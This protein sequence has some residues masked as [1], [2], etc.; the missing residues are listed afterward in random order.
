MTA[1]MNRSFLVFFSA[2]AICAAGPTVSVAQTAQT[3]DNIVFPGK[4]TTLSVHHYVFFG[5]NR[6][7]I[8]ALSHVFKIPNVE[9]AQITYSWRQLESVKD[10]YD[11]S[12]IQEDLAFLS[13][14]GKRLFIQIQDATF[15]PARIN[16][17]RYLLSDPVYSGGAAQQINDRVEE[18]KA[19]PAGWVARRWDPAVQER[20]HKLLFALGR[21]FDG[22]IEGINF[23]ETSLGFGGSGK[24]Y[25]KGYTPEIYRDAVIT[26]MRALKLA[27]PK[28]VA[29]Q[30]GNFMPGEW[31]PTDDKGYLVAVYRAARLMGVGMGG[32]DLLPHRPGQLG[33]SYPLLKAMAGQIPTGI[34]V[35]DGNFKDVN[36]KTGKPVTVVELVQFATEYLQVDYIF[37]GIEE[38]YFSGQV[39]PFLGSVVK[40]G[41]S[42]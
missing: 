23:D 15:D 35:Q 8:P 25:P 34:A 7:A 28:S 32:P 20:F 39:V 30:Y 33:S 6:E 27:F 41:A 17:P 11:F 18:D 3:V 2:G 31:R 24:H 19:T 13:Q 26:N 36:T 14:R 12:L 40:A 21:E 22:R 10:Q 42:P 38:P 1:Q 37:W 5:Q 4:S 16:I 9:G 29:M